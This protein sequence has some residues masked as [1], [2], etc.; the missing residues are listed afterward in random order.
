MKKIILIL[1][2]G[3]FVNS[4]KA[5]SD[6]TLKEYTG[7]YVFPEGGVIPDVT[8]VLEGSELSM[9][10][11]AGTSL[12]TKMGVDSF[13][14]VE[15]SGIAIFKRSEEKGIN[16]V[17]IEAAGYIMDG[18]KQE[19]KAIAMLPFIKSDLVLTTRKEIKVLEKLK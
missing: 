5:Q 4:V 10:S 6:S 1:L 12:L 2:L 9:I 16:A 14:V 18:V 15:F 11:S 17:H 19:V 13:T 7:L 8:V 3:L